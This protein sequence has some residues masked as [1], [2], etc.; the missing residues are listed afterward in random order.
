MRWMV[1]LTAL[2]SVGCT[3]LRSFSVTTIPEDRSRPVEAAGQRIVVLGINATND[4][5]DTLVADLAE[6]CP[7]GRVSGIITRYE[8]AMVVPIFAYAHR[9]YVSGHCVTATG[10][11]A[12]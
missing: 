11:G 5:A 4:F 9:V 2:A 12:Q 8:V 3:H 7:D 10:V 6:Q 1:L